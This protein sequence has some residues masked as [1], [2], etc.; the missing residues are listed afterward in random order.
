MLVLNLF[1]RYLSE[2]KLRGVVLGDERYQEEANAAR[3]LGFKSRKLGELDVSF[4]RD[5]YK[6]LGNIFRPP[7][8]EDMEW[9]PTLREKVFTL[10]AEL[11]Y[12]QLYVPLGIGWH[13][14]HVLTHLVFKPWEGRENLFYYEDAPYCCIPHST[15]YRLNELGKYEHAAENLS[16][17]PT[18]ELRA[19]LQSSMAYA[20]TALMK[21]LTP[22]IV[23]Q[24][25]VPVVGFY[26]YRLMAL[27]RKQA[28]V[29]PK[30]RLQA[31][32]I[33]IVGEFDSKVEAMALY[34]SQF[35]EFFK[36]HEDCSSMLSSYANRIRDGIGHMERYWAFQGSTD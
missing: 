10:L 21:N 3:F 22:W 28:N 1:T 5:A 23:R 33:P 13:V 14:D 24:I 26:F 4:R 15:R 11:D 17:A 16:L 34:R 20:G 19:W 31:H 9:L 25:A 29:P 12:E 35:K 7:V 6:K 36:G 32:V 8:L 18:N 30:R 2:V 27:H